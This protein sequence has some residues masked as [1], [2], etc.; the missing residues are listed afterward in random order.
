M[1]PRSSFLPYT[2]LF[3]SNN[4][5]M[6]G[7]PQVTSR[8]G[9]AR[10]AADNDHI[11]IVHAR[12]IMRANDHLS[13]RVCGSAQFARES[14]SEEHTSELQSPCNLVCSLLFEKKNT[15]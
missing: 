4:D 11:R 10:P 15:N 6:P 7:L 3:R 14:R 2:T 8:A 1:R 5:R 12:A 9:A 13:I